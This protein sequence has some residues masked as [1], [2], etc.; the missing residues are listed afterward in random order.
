VTILVINNGLIANMLRLE[1]HAVIES[2]GPV[3][4]LA[5]LNSRTLE[6]DVVL[7]DVEMKPISGLVFARNMA[8]SRIAIPLFF[9]AAP[10][11]AR[12]I[13]SS[14]GDN[15]LIEIPFT[16]PELCKALSKFRAR[17]KSKSQPENSGVASTHKD[18]RAR[19]PA[20]IRTLF[21]S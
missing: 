15:G 16:A 21:R 18:V 3:E 10:S 11:I 1:G 4:A 13:R 9:M 5:S 14:I 19:L 8:R 17:Y 20:T 12:A 2:P 6:V 7:S